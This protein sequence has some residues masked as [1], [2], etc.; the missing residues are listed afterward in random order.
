MSI[1]AICRTFIESFFFTPTLQRYHGSLRTKLGKRQKMNTRSIL[2]VHLPLS[3][4]YFLICITKN[5]L[6][7]LSVRHFRKKKKKKTTERFND[8][9][10]TFCLLI[11][12][13]CTFEKSNVMESMI[14]CACLHLGTL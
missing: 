7:T 8:N 13:G 1:S 14:E 11:S 3:V 4:S 12:R 5:K 9:A 10:F 2:R 6:L